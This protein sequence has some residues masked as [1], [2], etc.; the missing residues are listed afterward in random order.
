MIAQSRGGKYI[1]GRSTRCPGYQ[2]TACSR[3]MQ[4]ISRSA[5]YRE[6]PP[7]TR[8]AQAMEPALI[9]RL[10][11]E[12][13]LVACS[14]ASPA[15]RSL[16]ARIGGPLRRRRRPP[17]HAVRSRPGSRAAATCRAT[18][19]RGHGRTGTSI[20]RTASWPRHTLRPGSDIRIFDQLGIKNSGS[21]FRQADARSDESRRHR[22]SRFGRSISRKRRP[23]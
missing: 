18:P 8:T 4:F 17:G 20:D 10:P 15:T 19:V 23:A 1:D 3:P 21:L 14:G 22:G 11:A 2:A 16:V 9:H 6:H 12:S 13:R 5:L 7:D